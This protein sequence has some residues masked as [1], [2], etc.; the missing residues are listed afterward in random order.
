MVKR[1]LFATSPIAPSEAAWACSSGGNHGSCAAG[2]SRYNPP[3]SS[4][5]D[6]NGAVVQLVRIPACHAGGRGFESRPLRH[7]AFKPTTYDGLL[8]LY[9]IKYSIKKSL[10]GPSVPTL[11]TAECGERTGHASVFFVW[12]RQVAART[13]RMNEK[14]PGTRPGKSPPM[15]LGFG[16]T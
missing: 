1:P 6:G 7:F 5:S 8:V 12:L 11:K 4:S 16:Q 14:K 13:A 9:C 10:A 3:L 2:E 15:A